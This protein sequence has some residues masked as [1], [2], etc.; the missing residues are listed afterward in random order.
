MLFRQ[1]SRLVFINAA[2]VGMV[3]LFSNAPIR[4]VSAQQAPFLTAAFYGQKLITSL[5]DHANPTY[6]SDNNFTRFDGAVYTSP[7]NDLSSTNCNTGV[8]CYDG[9]DGID[10]A[11]SYERVLAATSG[12]VT[13]VRW[14]GNDVQTGCHYTANGQCGFGLFIKLQH[15]VGSTTY[16]TLYGHLSAAA[17][18]VGQYVVAGQIIGTSGAS[19]NTGIPPGPHLHFGVLNSAGQVVDPFGWSGQGA[20]PWSQTS[21]YMWLPGVNVQINGQ[22]QRLVTGPIADPTYNPHPQDCSSPAICVEDT[23]D[24]SAGFSKGSGGPFNGI[25]Q[26]DCGGW[27]TQNFQGYPSGFDGHMYYT[28][29]HDPPSD[30]WTLWQPTIPLPGIYEVWVFVPNTHA[31]SY[32][33]RYTIEAATEPPA[34]ALVDQQGLNNQWG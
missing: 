2:V 5:F 17:V 28:S 19:G 25:C 11:M 18:Y 20:D 13:Q 12:T 26:N 14:D 7:P 3:G 6:Q 22:G 23:T 29:A 30:S 9:H 34:T 32:Q 10:F 1:I 21:W 16:T 27:T 15:V 31:T 4:Q 8:D 24:N 33:A